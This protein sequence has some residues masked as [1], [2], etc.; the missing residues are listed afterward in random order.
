M[1]VRGLGQ[2]GVTIERH[3]VR[4]LRR[5]DGDDDLHHPALTGPSRT[6]LND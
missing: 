1:T 5:H 3:L 4:P 6:H 2:T